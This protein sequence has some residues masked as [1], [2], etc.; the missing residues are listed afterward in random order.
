MAKDFFEELGEAITKTAREIGGRAEVLYGTQKLKNKI[1]GE[2]RQIQ[3]IMEELGKVLYR[4]Y[5][6]GV[7]LDDL[8]RRLCEQIDQRMT[9]IEQYKEEMAGVRS[10]K[11]CPS[12]GTVV[13]Q[14]AAFCHHCGA[15]CTTKEKEEAAGSVIDGTMDETVK[16]E[17]A[18]AWKVTADTSEP[19]KENTAEEPQK[20]PVSEEV[21]EQSESEMSTETEEADQK[22]LTQEAEE[23][24]PEAEISTEQPE[25]E[26][27][28]IS[29]ASGERSE[30]PEELTSEV[31][32]KQSESVK[33]EETSE[34]KT[35]TEKM[36]EIPEG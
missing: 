28:L 9:R 36:P 2:E 13:D 22:I 24:Q 11:V 6:E 8:Q 27:K 10:K 4:R 23:K 17:E 32:K 16:S 33:T 31:Q 29:E 12:C 1:S 34:E 25:M 19:E 7:P 26:E 15:A 3:K 30:M 21:A 5:R 20:D 14:D 18:P 35:R